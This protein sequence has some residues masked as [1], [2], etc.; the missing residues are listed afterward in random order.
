M[1]MD[2]GCEYENL[3]ILLFLVD[4]GLRP[5]GRLQLIWSCFYVIHK[6][7]LILSC[8]GDYSPYCMSAL[9]W[10]NNEAP[11]MLLQLFYLPDIICVEL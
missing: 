1:K 6:F 7:L 11:V 8:C 10:L 3:R 5:R 2:L 4:F 9:V